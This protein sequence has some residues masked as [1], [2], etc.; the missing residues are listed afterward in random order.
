M[1]PK[2]KRYTQEERVQKGIY[3]KE[4]HRMQYKNNDRELKEL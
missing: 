3:S 4:K 1:I 2:E